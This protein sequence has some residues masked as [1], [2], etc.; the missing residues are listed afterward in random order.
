MDIENE[1]CSPFTTKET[2]SQCRDVTNT[3]LVHS[4]E[5]WAKV[6]RMFR[7]SHHYGLILPFI[8]VKSQCTGSREQRGICT[9]GDLYKNGQFVSYEELINQF[10]LEGKQH[11][12]RYLQIRD[13]VKFRIS[14]S[15]ENYI[16]DYM[17]KP[18][19]HCT[20]SRFYKSKH[21]SVNEEST[22]VKQW[23]S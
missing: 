7:L 14:N 19:E 10:K 22:S 1:L 20:A 17:N 23:T 21:F 13:C 2:L 11:F 6:H 12:W 4:E 8:L 3:V 5:V 18:L 15:A 16:M 9:I